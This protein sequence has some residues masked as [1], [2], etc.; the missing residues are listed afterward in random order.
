M[1]YGV[2]VPAE[3]VAVVAGA[4]L[5]MGE[6]G[7]RFGYAHEAPGCV[8]VGGVMVGVVGLGEGELGGVNS[9]K[10]KG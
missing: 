2:P 9:G 10:G 7:I 8:R 4:L 5:A 1:R 3:D 6:D